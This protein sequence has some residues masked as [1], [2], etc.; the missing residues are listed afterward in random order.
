MTA[1]MR[2]VCFLSATVI[3]FAATNGTAADAPPWHNFNLT[4]WLIALPI[5]AVGQKGG[6]D[7]VDVYPITDA[8][9]GRIPNSSTY[10]FMSA[11]GG[12][13]F[14]APV[15]GARLP[16]QSTYPRCEL[17]EMGYYKT[18]GGK[19]WPLSYGGQLDATLA[20]NQVPM[21]EP[22]KA[23][24]CQNVVIGQMHFIP[25]TEG[26]MK[27]FYAPAGIS[28]EGS[29]Y[30]VFVQISLIRKHLFKNFGLVPTSAGLSL[31]QKFSY[32]IRVA[33]NISTI[34]ATANSQTFTVN[35]DRSWYDDPAYTYLFQAGVYD[36]ANNTGEGTQGSGA[37]KVTFYNL[38]IHH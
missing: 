29:K 2:L 3:L 28:L 36:G 21:V 6:H 13:T 15:D 17:A 26:T 37:G 23:G 32:R 8:T 5:N 9:M 10:F 35:P 24:C 14:Y 34:S 30:N 27:V 20:V 7:A 1:T 22:A 38:A 16:G 19:F 4:E 18:H 31:G 11:D 33:N 25:S 12:M